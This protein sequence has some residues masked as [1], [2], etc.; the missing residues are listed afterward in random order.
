MKS[1]KYHFIFKIEN[2]NQFRNSRW[3][4]KYDE[5][6]SKFVSEHVQV[7]FPMVELLEHFL[8]L[9]TQSTSLFKTFGSGKWVES[10]SSKSRRTLTRALAISD[11]GNRLMRN[12]TCMA[13]FVSDYVSMSF[14]MQRWSCTYTNAFSLNL[15]RTWTFKN[16]HVRT[17]YK[18]CHIL[19]VNLHYLFTLTKISQLQVSRLSYCR[20]RDVVYIEPYRSVPSYCDGW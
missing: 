6:R 4:H 2:H 15:L 1:L 12:P 8:G 5:L 9:L 18:I 14:Y 20:L 3:R 19:Y 10:I 13:T 17:K 16:V 11:Q 7:A